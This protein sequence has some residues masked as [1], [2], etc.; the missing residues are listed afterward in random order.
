MKITRIAWFI[1][2]TALI[3]A[4]SQQTLPTEN[5]KTPEPITIRLGVSLTPQELDTYQATLQLVNDKHPEWEVILENT[6]QSGI[7]EKINSQ[8]SANDLPDVVRLPGLFTQQW[9]RKTA[10]LDLTTYID[11]S[12]LDL[13][14]FY[15]GPLSQFEYKGM[16]WGIPDTATPD[17]L[18]YNKEMFDTAGLAY[19]TDNWTFEDMRET[20]ILLTLDAS[21]KNPN[22]PEF[23]PTTIQQWGWNGGISNIW[24]RHLVRPFGGDFCENNDCTLMKFTDPITLEAIKWWASLVNTDYAAPYDP[25]GGSQ[26]GIPGDP[27]TA[28]KAAMGFNGFFAVGQL[29]EMGSINYDIVQPFAGNDGD[30]YTPLSTNGYLISA[31]SQNPEAAW[32]LVME[33]IDTNFLKETWGMP[34]HS[35]P[36]RRSSAGSVINSLQ[37]PK[38]QEAIVDA[39]EYGEV[40]KPFTRSA[41]EAY[42]KTSDLFIQAMKGEIELEQ[43]MAEIESIANET[44]M[45][46][47]EP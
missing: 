44:L 33:L 40:F 14:D 5:T 46:D 34:G 21:G 28:G 32:M 41:F 45:R 11:D 17:V 22:D 15:T 16:L 3:S 20:A 7:V 23:D 36:A 42:G 37:P 29:N 6:P 4:C 13:D 43:V 27:F 9:I 8:L 31:N 30:R 26:T 24:Q 25:Y 1:L 47:R 19:P 12:E 10:F 18:F 38:N 39:I 35:V 2:I